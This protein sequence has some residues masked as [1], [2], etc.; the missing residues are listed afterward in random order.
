[1]DALVIPN[2]RV[3][4]LIDTRPALDKHA[5]IPQQTRL[6]F[7]CLSLI[8]ELA[9]EGLLQSANH[10][11]G[12]GLPSL[13][14]GWRGRLPQHKEF[15]RMARVVI[16][17]EQKFLRSYVGALSL[18]ARRVL[19]ISEDLT[20]F[21]SEYFRDYI[22][23]R[24]FARSL[25][26]EDLNIVTR[27]PFRIARGSWTAMHACSLISRKLGCPLFPKIRTS[28][29][30]YMITETPYP[31]TVDRR[32]KLIVRYH[33]AIPLL[34]P[35]T[36]SKRRHHQAF[37]YNALRRN[38]ESGAWF[39]CVSEATRKD[40]VSIFPQVE[41]RSTTIHNI[42]SHDYF[43]APSSATRVREIIRTR[44]NPRIAR[45]IDPSLKGRLF[46]DNDPIALDRYLL[47]V[48]T[49]EP[50]KNH[51]TLLAAW[52]RLHAEQLPDLKLLLVGS[53]GW[54][55]R[56]IMSKF[57]PWLARGE[58]FL[59]EDVPTPELRLLYKHAAATVCPSFAEG[60]D[61][62][63]VEAMKSGG[64]VVASDIP[65][66]REIYEGAAEY[67]N[68]YSVDE[69]VSQLNNV[70]DSKR[71]GYRER[72]VSAGAKVATRYT[73]ESIAPKWRQFLAQNSNASERKA[74][75]IIQTGQN[76]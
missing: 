62:S 48:S 33:D 5:G 35:H 43:D 16:M 11:L 34:M 19:G 63:G 29:F 6:L 37:H 22:W 47:M 2:R 69:L 27:V 61:L 55:Q 36:I 9:V 65:V 10:S 20:R 28:E 13:P 73:F 71:I 42:V 51:L 1:M 74:A 64:V 21:D 23:R 45:V 40:L 54:H 32:T 30:D 75:A 57:A 67:F 14:G 17:L 12:K 76:E 38:V 46:D 8:D 50:R 41:P 60:F 4:V 3:R 52:E 66:H 53:L 39:V 24:L 25:P 58:A 18:A 7:R 44:L 56:P 49:V 59:L 68:P 72:L 15:D 26:P 31:A 70:L